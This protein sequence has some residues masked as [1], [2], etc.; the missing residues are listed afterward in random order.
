MN[1][2]KREQARRASEFTPTRANPLPTTRWVARNE[3]HLPLVEWEGRSLSDGEGHCCLESPDTREICTKPRQPLPNP[4]H[5]E[6]AMTGRDE[7]IVEGLS[8]LRFTSQ[9]SSSKRRDQSAFSRGGSSIVVRASDCDRVPKHTPARRESEFTPTKTNPLPTTRWVARN[10]PHIPLVEWEGRSLSDGEGHCCLESPESPRDEFPRNGEFFEYRSRNKEVRRKKF[11][12]T[13][14]VSKR[15]SLLAALIILVCGSSLAFADE[16]N[17]YPPSVSLT[18]ATDSQTMLAISTDDSGVTRDV[19]KEIT[20][21]C[22]AKEL[23]TIENATLRS[24][25]ASNEPVT[26]TLYAE[27]GDDKLEIPITVSNTKNTPATS[28]RLDVLP[29]LT[30]AGCNSGTCHGSSRGKDGFGLSLFGFD[31]AG[32]YHRITR[33][34]AARRINLAV[35]ASSLLLEK[36]VGAVQHTGGKRFD[37][38]SDHYRTIHRWLEQGAK[39]DSEDV[40]SVEKVEIYPPE[41]VIQGFGETRPLRVIAHYTDGSDRDIT[42]LAVYF[43]NDEGTANVTDGIITGTARGEAFITARFETHTVGIPVLVLPGELEFEP[44]PPTG[45]YIDLLITEKLN[46]IRV[47][48]S[49]LCSDEE[50]LRRVTLDV[51]GLLPT[52]EEF[53]SFVESNDPEK[54]TTRIDELLA[55]DEFTDLW[56]AKWADLLMIKPLNNLMS[57]KST[58][59]YFEWVRAQLRSGV[60]LDKMV[61]KIINSTGTSFD[62]PAVNFYAREPNRL[63]CAEDAAQIFLGIRTQCAQC[64]NHPFDRWTMD[65]YYGFAALFVQVGRKRLE[66][67]RDYAVFRSGAQTKHPVT[68]KDVMP[69]YLGGDAPEI[70][71]GLERREFAAEWMTSPEN[72]WFARNWAN[73]IWAHFLGRGIVEPVDDFRVSNPPTNAPLLDGLAEK[74]IEYNYD[75]R[76]LARDILTS[77][78]YQRSSRTVAGNEHDSRNFARATVRRIPAVNL[79]DCFSQVTAS[80]TK[81]PRLPKGSRAVETPDP[82]P[83]NYFFA[84]FGRA[85]RTSACACETSSQP[86]LSQALHLLNGKSIHSKIAQG[87]LVKSWLKEERTPEQ[88]IHSIYVRSLGRQPTEKE[89]QDLLASVSEESKQQDLEDVFWAVLN[90]REF[91]FIK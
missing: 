78:A 24:A 1:D 90:S 11:S 85:K 66:D 71:N 17:I 14:A 12:L 36:S 62:N 49:D 80:D 83:S 60:P 15:R 82:T 41:I 43:S 40:A 61:R 84:A 29:V 45:S 31:P 37:V 38:D 77:D 55:R 69:K 5:Y 26:G 10:E 34:L 52:E 72:P 65:D 86:T 16:L 51:V 42:N 76:K 53:K 70:R 8:D 9:S 73:R 7:K 13:S 27:W 39:D 6:K 79:L 59:L 68:K 47:P 44:Q 25:A 74:L 50:F 48:A 19:T 46:K 87:K 88:I 75:F 2:S 30:K 28:F 67:E 23:A 64:H 54:R 32:D 35:P 22:E 33:E 63:K 89:S 4:P 58:L 18:S 57:E 21:R 20:W 81:Y 91:L 3:P 56:A